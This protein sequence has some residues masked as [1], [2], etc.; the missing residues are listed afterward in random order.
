MFDVYAEDDLNQVQIYPEFKA[1]DAQIWSKFYGYL[2]FPFLISLCDH[3]VSDL[4]TRLVDGSVCIRAVHIPGQS[5]MRLRVSAYPMELHPFASTS[6]GRMTGPSAGTNMGVVLGPFKAG[7]A[8]WLK[9]H[10]EAA[11]HAPE[12]RAQAL[13]GL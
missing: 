11:R 10:K 2:I 3:T 8:Q 1:T 13:T 12:I 5:A 9:D 6:R 7:A 4:H